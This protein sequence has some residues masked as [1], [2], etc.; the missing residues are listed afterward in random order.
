MGSSRAAGHVAVAQED[1][2]CADVREES[3]AGSVR[4]TMHRLAPT[5]QL[6]FGVAALAT[7]PKKAQKRPKQ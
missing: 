3:H 7:A 4:C 6:T 5:T 1:D 2:T